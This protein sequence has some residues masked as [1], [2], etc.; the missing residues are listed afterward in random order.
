M[1]AEEFSALSK[2][3]Q[4]EAMIR[5]GDMSRI[6][7][8]VIAS[9]EHAKSNL[10]PEQAK[11]LSALGIPMRTSAQPSNT[12]LTNSS[13]AASSA[14]RDPAHNILNVDALMRG[15]VQF[16]NPDGAL[17]TMVIINRANSMQLLKK[18]YPNQQE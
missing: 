5:N 17:T 6:M 2:S 10:S 3:E 15:H 12:R 7:E 18:E 13:A 16:T 4:R 8:L 9:S 1:S 14:K 11:K